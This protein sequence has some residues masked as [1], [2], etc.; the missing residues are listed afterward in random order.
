MGCH[1]DLANIEAEIYSVILLL[2]VSLL[3][4]C[5]TM[6]K[7]SRKAS[8]ESLSTA[9]KES[10]SVKDD[11]KVA[12][13]KTISTSSKKKT[14]KKAGKQNV[15][16]AA[17]AGAK[18]MK[19]AKKEGQ[20]K[21]RPGCVLYIGHIPHGFYEEQMQKFFSQFGE[22]KRVRVSRN[23]K[24]GGSRGYG[25]LEFK[26]PEVA[27]IAADTMHNY[28]LYEKYL[29][30]E[31]VPKE[32][33]HKKM[34][35]GANKA[36]REIPRHAIHKHKME[37][38][39]TESGKKRRMK[40]LVKNE[41][42]R[43][44]KLQKLGIDYEFEGFAEKIGPLLNLNDSVAPATVSSNE[45]SSRRRTTKRTRELET[46]DEITP[47]KPTVKKQ[48]STKKQKTVTPTKGAEKGTKT[49]GSNNSAVA[50][51]TRQR[52]TKSKQ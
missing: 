37:R 15:G 29:V 10:V 12:E 16:A 4:V 1:R 25:F 22:V 49:P 47:E 2:V 11:S 27:K 52:K 30:V 20:I 41:R 50:R 51:R 42:L 48:G 32:K 36:W 18:Q 17:A 44:E 40:Q 34:F 3:S 38:E 5:D 19:P 26:Q 28:E 39:T 14:T 6:P 21:P 24:T 7:R 45:G 9:D 46:Q 43:K 33:L 35:E 13:P 31:V 8:G 23:M